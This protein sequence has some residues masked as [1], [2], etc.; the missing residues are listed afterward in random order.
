M[1]D[2]TKEALGITIREL[3]RQNDELRRRYEALLKR[4]KSERM[5]TACLGFGLGKVPPR[6]NAI[7]QAMP[8]V[9]FRP[10]RFCVSRECAGHF[11]IN[12]LKVGMNSQFVSSEP[13]PARLF[14]IENVHR[15][16]E[17]ESEEDFDAA[18][19]IVFDSAMPG[20][21]VT[22]SVT[23][24]DDSTIPFECVMVGITLDTGKNELPEGPV[25]L[26]RTPK[27]AS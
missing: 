25:T 3:S 27:N 26:V 8:Q 17:I 22:V 5:V 11:M 9:P 23:R 1:S 19:P 24:I 4:P 21:L 18:L 2:Q 6:G 14:G 15:L 16:R 10:E 7:V 13:I 20:M 12:D